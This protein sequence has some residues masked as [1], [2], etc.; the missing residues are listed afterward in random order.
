M[1][2]FEIIVEGGRLWGTVA[3]QGDPVLLLHGGP[4][5]PW[6]YLE[7]LMDELSS[8]YRVAVYQQRGLPP[9]TAGAPYDVRAQVADVAAVLDGLGWER[10]LL[11]GHSWGGHLLLHV[12]A[13]FPERVAAALVIDT[14]GG[15]GDGGEGEFD[16][17]LQRRTAPEDVE[18]AE[19]LDQQ[20]MEG[21]GT[22][23]DLAESLRL[24]W[25]AYFAEPA[26][27]PPFPEMAFSVEAYA[28][29]LASLRDELP[30]LAGRLAGVAVPTLFVHGGASPM[31][32]TAS[33]ASAEAIGPSAT[34]EVLAGAGHFPWIERP[35]ALRSS[36][37]RLS[38]AT[39]A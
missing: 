5:L 23:A 4:G 17:E 37:D 27:A 1:D 11:A 25:P 26:K 7:P 39:A 10:A 6:T 8:G 2:E 20:A 33:T 15:V 35:G 21:Q 38:A 9:S 22:E 13:D 16:A 28:A 32:V 34:V 3:G 31:P 18:R 12:L 24:F 29:T 30:G 19:R 14:L 36:L